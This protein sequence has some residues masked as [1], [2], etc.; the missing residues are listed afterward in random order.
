[1]WLS[2]ELSSVGPPIPK[3]YPNWACWLFTSLHGGFGDGHTTLFWI[4]SCFQPTCYL[5]LCL[6][7]T[8]PL[9]VTRGRGLGR[10]RGRIHLCSIRESLIPDEQDLPQ[11]CLYGRR[12]DT[13]VRNPSPMLCKAYELVGSPEQTLAESC[14]SLSLGPWEQG[15]TLFTSFQEGI[16]VTYIILAFPF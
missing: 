7:H 3:N 9:E 4:S 12:T 1:M 10:P 16:L 11:C 5:Q 6:D 13:L 14:L 8:W 2:S 15:Q